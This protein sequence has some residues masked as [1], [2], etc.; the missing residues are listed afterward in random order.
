MRIARF[1]ALYDTEGM[2]VQVFK[3]V[4]IKQHNKRSHSCSN[5]A[6]LLGFGQN[7]L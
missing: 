7:V 6:M 5:L 4:V 1:L 3:L 2:V